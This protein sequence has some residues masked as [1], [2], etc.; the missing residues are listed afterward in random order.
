MTLQEVAAAEYDLIV[1][2]HVLEHLPYPRASLEQVAAAMK[3]G[4]IL[5]L[6]V[7]HEDL[8]RQIDDPQERLTG[9]RHWHEHVNFFTFESLEA[10]LRHAGLRVVDWLSLP[11]TAGGKDGHV[12]SI[13]ARRA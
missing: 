10:V 6:E 2:S 12:F 1:F 4:T 3:S 9:K 5:Y 11:V 13:I 7:P 8:V